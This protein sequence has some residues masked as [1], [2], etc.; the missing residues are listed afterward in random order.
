MS[1][2]AMPAP[3]RRPTPP[4]SYLRP[5]SDDSISFGTNN[6]FRRPS[7]PTSAQLSPISPVVDRERPMSRN[8]FLDPPAATNSAPKT[9]QDA[10]TAKL[11]DDIFRDPTSPERSRLNGERHQNYIAYQSMTD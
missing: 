3:D 5:S 10:L 7:P 9:E 11:V 1:L 8:P 4:N 6:P 2:V